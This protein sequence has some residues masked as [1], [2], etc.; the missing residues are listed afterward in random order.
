V[1]DQCC[2]RYLVQSARH[3]LRAVTMS[4]GGTLI[5]LSLSLAD[6]GA[7]TCPDNRFVVLS[8]VVAG[9]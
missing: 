4:V 2:G 8:S 7:H 6:C 3:A 1:R 5:D 9:L